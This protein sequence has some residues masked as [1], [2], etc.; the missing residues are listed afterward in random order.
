MELEDF[1]LVAVHEYTVIVDSTSMEKLQK[2]AEAFNSRPNRKNILPDASSDV[3][4]LNK[5]AAP[6]D[7]SVSRAAILLEI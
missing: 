4:E 6:Y 2:D 3:K 5:D 1:T 7:A